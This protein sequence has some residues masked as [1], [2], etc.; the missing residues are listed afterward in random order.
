MPMH[1]VSAVVVDKIKLVETA[2]GVGIDDV[3]GAT[4]AAPRF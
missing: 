1:V 2:L 3:I 4:L